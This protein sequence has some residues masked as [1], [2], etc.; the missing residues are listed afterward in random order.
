MQH[1]S[2]IVVERDKALDKL[3]LAIASEMSLPI[4]AGVIASPLRW[5]VLEEAEARYR[6]WV[7]RSNSEKKPVIRT[8]VDVALSNLFEIDYQ[9]AF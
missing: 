4:V 5:R 8:K 3:Y 9:P 1:P 6:D 7:L 2:L